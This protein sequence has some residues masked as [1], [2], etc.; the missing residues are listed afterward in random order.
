MAKTV[1]SFHRA[2]DHAI[3]GTADP[4]TLKETAAQIAR[5][6]TSGDDKTRRFYIHNGRGIVGAG[7]CRNG[8]WHD[9]LRENYAPFEA[10]ARSQRTTYG[11]L[12]DPQ[13]KEG[14]Q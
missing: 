14:Q 12:N 11:L 3:R 1:Y 2:E 10:A 13:K 8:T 7:L 9:T 4:A 5:S 6:T